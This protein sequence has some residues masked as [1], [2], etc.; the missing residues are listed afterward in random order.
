MRAVTHLLIILSKIHKYLFRFNWDRCF[1]LLLFL[2]TQALWIPSFYPIGGKKELV[3]ETLFIRI[4]ERLFVIVEYCYLYNNVESSKTEKGFRGWRIRI[5][6]QF[7]S[8]YIKYLRQN[9]KEKQWMSVFAFFY[10]VSALY[11]IRPWACFWNSLKS[12]VWNILTIR[13][14]L[15]GCLML[16]FWVD[17][18]IFTLSFRIHHFLSTALYSMLIQVIWFVSLDLLD[19]AR[20]ASYLEHEYSLV[21]MYR[22]LSCKHLQVKST[23]S[24]DVFDCMA[25]FATCHKNHVSVFN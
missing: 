9:K 7:L 2:C 10:K 5:R 8:A 23:F 21:F 17:L 4:N 24:M 13:S 6:R 14:S 3:P 19:L 18:L 25:H 15:L 16:V 20:F 11:F 22:V 12:I 1:E